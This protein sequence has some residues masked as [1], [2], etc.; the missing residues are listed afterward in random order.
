MRLNPGTRFGRYEIVGLLGAGGMGE[1]YHATDTH[2]RRPVAIKILPPGA[3]RDGESRARFRRE[4]KAIAALRHPNICVLHDAADIDGVDFLVMEFLEGETLEQRLRR[5]PLQW[6]QL[7]RHANEI[8]SALAAAHAQGIVHRDLK[9]GNIMLTATGARLL[10]FGLAKPQI[11]IGASDASTQVASLSVT[12]AIM[13]TPGYMAPEQLQGRDAD[14]RS[15]IFA[16][17]AILYEMATG[18]KAFP[19]STPAS[20]IA[21]VLTHD[22]D[23]DALEAMRLPPTFT[24]L[25]MTC[26]AKDPS[27]RWQSAVDVAHAIRHP[28]DA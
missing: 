8:V 13:G 2:L 1:V 14:P 16:L 11:G 19:G 24:S 6:G 28:L 20:L 4:A 15:D 12:G 10:D 3:T 22:P 5:G 9:P 25:V 18:R 7:L 17:G 23:A 26:L 21:A 27:Q